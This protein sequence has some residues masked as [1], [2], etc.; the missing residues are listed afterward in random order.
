MKRHGLPVAH[1]TTTTP[2]V[3]FAA[4]V[5]HAAWAPA[6]GRGRPA[7]FDSNDV[8]VPLNSTTGGVPVVTPKV[9]LE[10]SGLKSGAMK[11]GKHAAA[12]TT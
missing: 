7:N 1:R 10:R 6:P 3:S 5:D 8:S 11:L 12:K 9:T 4:H 2:P